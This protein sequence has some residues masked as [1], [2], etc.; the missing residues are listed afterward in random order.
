MQ[1]AGAEWERATR[2]EASLSLLLLDVDRFKFIND[3]HDHGVGDDLPQ[4]IARPVRVGL[5][6]FDVL[7]RYGGEEFVILLPETE[8]KTAPLAAKQAG[9][10]RVV[11]APQET[12]QGQR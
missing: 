2:F 9:R 3:E 5:R 10:D 7:A 8:M 12:S 4:R 1:V 11:E 6:G